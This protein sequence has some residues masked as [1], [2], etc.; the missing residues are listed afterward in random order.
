MEQWCEGIRQLLTRTNASENTAH[1]AI[2][3]RV[4]ISNEMHDVCVIC[5][6]VHTWAGEGTCEQW[7]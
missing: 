5:E 6:H 1:R 7:P 4:H 3:N 2:L